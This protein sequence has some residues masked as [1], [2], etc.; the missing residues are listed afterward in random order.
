MKIVDMFAFSEFACLKP[1][2]QERPEEYTLAAT[3]KEYEQA[4][5]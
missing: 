1:D 2:C 4:E 5:G 3:A